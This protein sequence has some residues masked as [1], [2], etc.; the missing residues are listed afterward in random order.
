LGA[1]STKIEEF[2][3]SASFNSGAESKHS[4]TEF[5]PSEDPFV[6]TFF[7]P[8]IV[9]FGR[10]IGQ[11]RMRFNKARA[12]KFGLGRPYS[13][14]LYIEKFVFRIEVHDFREKRHILEHKL[15]RSGGQPS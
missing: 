14:C 1:E 10:R 13:T 9:T 5:Q 7:G 15:C 12:P 11:T 8:R 3:F 6:T 4:D 2:I